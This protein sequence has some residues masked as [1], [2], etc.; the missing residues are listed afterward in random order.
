MTNKKWFGLMIPSRLLSAMAAKSQQS[1]LVK[2]AKEYVAYEQYQQAESCY[3]QALA[4][5]PNDT[6]SRVGLGHVL[7]RMFRHPEALAELFA[8][9]SFDEKNV[10][11]HYLIGCVKEK[12]GESAIAASHYRT[13]LMLKPD[14]ELAYR[15]ACRIMNTLGQISAAHDLISAGLRL[16]PEFAD[17]HFYLGNVYLTEQ[18][19]DLALDCYQ[20][21]IALGADHSA[22]HGYL[23]G[24]LLRRNELVTARQHLERAVELEPHNTEA[25]HDL[26]V[27]YQRLGHVEKAIQQQREAIAQ[28]PNFL[29]ARSCL[30]YAMSISPSYTPHQYLQE[31][32]RYGSI[33]KKL[34]TEVN[35]TIN[36]KQFRY[37]HLNLRVGFVS[38]DLRWHVVTRFL[39]G[40]LDQLVNFPVEIYAFSN[41]VKDD[42]VTQRL[43]GKVS[44][45]HDIAS[46]SDEVAVAQIRGCQID[47]LLDLSGHTGDNRLGVF[48]MR[49]A[50]IQVSWLGYWA[51]TGVHAMDYLIAD[52]VSVPV[53]AQGNFSEKICY[54][55]ETRFCLSAPDDETAYPVS[56]LPAD[57]SGAITFGCFQSLGKITDSVLL[58]WSHL[59][60]AVPESS[61]RFQTRYL[62]NPVVK[63]DFL[64]RLE[65]VGISVHRVKLHGGTSWAAYLKAHDEVDMILDTFPYPGGTTTADA[66]WMGV[67]TLT[68]SGDTM[69]A[70]Q[71]ASLLSCVGLSDWIARD[72]DDYIARAVAH[73]ADTKKLAMLR[74]RLRTQALASPLF[75]SARFTQHLW[76]ALQG[77]HQQV[78]AANNPLLQRRR[79]H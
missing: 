48:A 60:A 36:A 51:S 33:A 45:W 35:D 25:H 16:N 42:E 50:R 72:I 76:T 62:E 65:G 30:L 75:D 22:L 55:P 46:L 39:E 34:A 32:S 47:I 37:T 41:N 24:V 2:R 52:P 13:A 53:T 11:A 79:N 7:E 10:E 70:R 63:N 26:G 71:G 54:L 68:M 8:V 27:V 58:V 64:M 15:G 38:G 61:L 69:L 59:L 40:V 5:D 23:G 9:L 4:V 44:H 57:S 12:C 31:A 29:P 21:A 66:L 1:S 14:F 6:N 28:K 67:P 49:A 73:A 78:D 56:A 77:L 43:K 18:E 3:R 17:Y 19:W 20:E 74:D